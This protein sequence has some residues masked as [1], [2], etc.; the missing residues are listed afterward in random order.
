MNIDRIRD[1]ITAIH[2]R[3]EYPSA[4]VIAIELRRPSRGINDREKREARRVMDSLGIK[5]KK[6]GN[7]FPGR[8]PSFGSMNLK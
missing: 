4:T 7:P 5:P 2:S 1:A 8:M 3:G 6:V